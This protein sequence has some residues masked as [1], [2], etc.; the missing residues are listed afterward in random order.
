MKEYTWLVIDK[1]GTKTYLNI[2]ANNF[3]KAETT[4]Q[5]IAAK[6]KYI[7]IEYIGWSEV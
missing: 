5:I 2:Y 6:R 4:V 7:I 3:S 1:S